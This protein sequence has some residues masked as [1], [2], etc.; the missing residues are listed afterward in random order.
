MERWRE[1]LREGE[2]ERCFWR[3]DKECSNNND[4]T[5]I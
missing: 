3:V 5:S 2:A 1:R 4:N